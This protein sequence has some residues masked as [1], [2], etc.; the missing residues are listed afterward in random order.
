MAAQLAAKAAMKQ[1]MGKLG[2]ALGQKSAGKNQ[3]DAV[4]DTF[5]DSNASAFD[6]APANY[7]PYLNLC[8]IDREILSNR[9]KMVVDKAHAIFMMANVGSLLNLAG[10]LVQKSWVFA[11]ISAA[12][13]LVMFLAQLFLFEY[14]F[15]ACY[16]TSRPMQKLYLLIG[17]LNA[18]AFGVFAFVSVGWFN[19][20]TSLAEDLPMPLLM[21]FG[22]ESMVWTVLMSLQVHATLSMHGVR[23]SHTLGLSPNASP[24]LTDT[25]AE[26][27]PRDPR[28]A[29]V[30]EIRA[31]YAK[32]DAVVLAQV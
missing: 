5:E 22:V 12:S 1:K 17:L 13:F 26:A 15:R 9:A 29:R 11:G 30:D 3:R 10:N 32:D 18:A 7:P 6:N 28:Q 14:T 19:G 23:S 25:L 2:E 4:D 20:W 21:F 27:A 16:K 8:Y 24:P 31:R